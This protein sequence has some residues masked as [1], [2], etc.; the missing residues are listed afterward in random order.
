MEIDREVSRI[1]PK[2][3]R[4]CRKTQFRKWLET[5]REYVDEFYHIFISSVSKAPAQVEDEPHE[6]LE[7]ASEEA[8]EEASEEVLEEA[9][10][11]V[12]IAPKTTGYEDF[13]LFLYKKSL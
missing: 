7:E 11:E 13:A 8:L 9:P 1:I 3:L 6:A 5:N 10:E 12:E 4:A 2:Y